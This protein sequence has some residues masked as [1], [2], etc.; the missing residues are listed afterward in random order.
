MSDWVLMFVLGIAAISAVYILFTSNILFGAFSLVVTLVSLAVAYLLLNAE[1]VAVTQIMIYV[2]GIVVL[3]IFGVMLTQDLSKEGN[4]KPET[5]HNKFWAFIVAG[6][7]FS[8]IATSAVQIT[9]TAISEVVNSSV[10]QIGLSLL[11]DFLLLFELA[12]ILLL[13][14]LIGAATLASNK[15]ELN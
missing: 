15:K 5:S 9:H 6:T 13:V 10:K 11:T 12:A 14:A 1:F 2:G 8:L 7:I 3:I 4:D